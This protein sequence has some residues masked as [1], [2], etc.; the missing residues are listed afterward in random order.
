MISGAI[1][2]AFNQ[3]LLPFAPSEA[4]FNYTWNLSRNISM[5][6]ISVHDMWRFHDNGILKKSFTQI[7]S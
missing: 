5:W 1:N 3:S 6:Q 2:G 4:Q 7:L